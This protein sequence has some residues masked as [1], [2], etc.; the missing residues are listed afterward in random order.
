MEQARRAAR[1]GV[2]ERPARRWRRWRAGPA[3]PAGPW[4]AAER[5]SGLRGEDQVALDSRERAGMSDGG[6]A[7]D[8]PPPS[9]GTTGAQAVASA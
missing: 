7:R 6:N 1:H 5:S 3:M 4:T 9:P 8:L 2:D